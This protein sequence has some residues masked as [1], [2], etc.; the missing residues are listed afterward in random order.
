MI[1]LKFIGWVFFG[2]LALTLF[3][4]L[5]GKPI[6]KFLL[7]YFIKRAQKDME[8]QSRVYEQYV[9]GHSPFEDSIYV[10]E[11]TRVSIQRGQNEAAP[12]PRD[13]N[14]AL[15]EEVEFEDLD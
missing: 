2:L 9:Q 3:M 5:F 4:R 7:R 1:L 8:R 13:I 14:D 15:I 12:K 10:D 11:N 6:S